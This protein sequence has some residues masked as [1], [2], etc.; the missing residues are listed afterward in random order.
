MNAPALLNEFQ[1]MG[2][3]LEARGDKLRAEA[4]EHILT[5]E[6]VAELRAHK[7][8]IL[9]VLRQ[10]QWYVFEYRRDGAKTWSTLTSILPD[11]TTAKV[12]AYLEAFFG[13]SVEVRLR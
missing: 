12:K 4:P 13:C 9:K 10:R 6:L 5:A 1:R 7:Q 3:R 2:I 11:D 8:E